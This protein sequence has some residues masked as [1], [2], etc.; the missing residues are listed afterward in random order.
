MN[1]GK[2]DDETNQSV[3]NRVLA[4]FIAAVAEDEGLV[5]IAPRL[6]ITLLNTDNLK[7]DAMRKALFG[8]GDA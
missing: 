3:A 1:G 5:D 8:E 2:N 7:E 6:K 4:A